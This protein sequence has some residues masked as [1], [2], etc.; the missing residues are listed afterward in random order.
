MALYPQ[1]NGMPQ[2]QVTTYWRASTNAS[3]GVCSAVRIGEA[4]P[5]TRIIRTTENAAN[6]VS[7]VPMD[8]QVCF[9]S[10]MPVYLPTR[11]VPPSVRPVI[12][13]V[14][15]CVT[16]VPVDTAATLAGS[17]NQPITARSTAPYSAWMILAIRNG[18]VKRISTGSTRPSV[19]RFFSVMDMPPLLSARK[20]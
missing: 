11:M 13:L 15:I 5:I 14:T 1:M 19:N 3:S 17:Q 8:L 12:R 2:P 6:T 16:C 4:R 20:A 18:T 10:R 7:V 9:S